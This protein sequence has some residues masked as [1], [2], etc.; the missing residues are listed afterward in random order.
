MC[1]INKWT[2]KKTKYVISISP[3]TFFS[4]V[5]LSI[6]TLALAHSD[7]GTCSFKSVPCF[8]RLCW[9]FLYYLHLL[10]CLYIPN[11][12][13]K[14]SHSVFIY[15]YQIALMYIVKNAPNIHSRHYIRWNWKF[16][17]IV[18]LVFIWGQKT[19]LSQKY[20][21][22]GTHGLVY[23]LSLYMLFEKKDQIALQQ[24]C[25]SYA[26]SPSLWFDIK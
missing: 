3:Y 24:R 5:W 6:L 25:H 19:V 16:L 18:L 10:V 9:P 1:F 20:K 4:L 13:S 8:C 15:L 21:H 23:V 26:C 11:T 17:W 12:A 22:Q 2:Q 14:T 7:L